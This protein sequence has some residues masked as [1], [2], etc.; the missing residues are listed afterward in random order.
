MH[1]AD[2]AS[3]D[4][5]AEFRHRRHRGPDVQDPDAAEVPLF[6]FGQ[7]SGQSFKE[8]TE[9]EAHYF[10]WAESQ[11]RPSALLKQYLNWVT[12][13]YD[14]NFDKRK[15]SR[16]T[17]G[18]AF[19]ADWEKVY[20]SHRFKAKEPSK[21]EKIFRAKQAQ[22][23]KCN[24]C[25]PFSKAG[26][27][28]HQTVTTCTVCGF[29]EKEKKDATIRTRCPEDCPHLNTNHSSSSKTTHR[30]FCLDCGSVTYE[31]PQSVY[32]ARGCDAPGVGSASNRARP[33]PPQPEKVDKDLN[34]IQALAVVNLLPALAKTYL[35]KSPD[36]RP[37]KSSELHG[38]LDDAIDM[39]LDNDLTAQHSAFMAVCS[40]RKKTRKK[41]LSPEPRR[42]RSRKH[43]KDEREPRRKSSRS[44]PAREQVRESSRTHVR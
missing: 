43:D 14:I 28:A 44:S 23:A 3:S 11:T 6:S 35:K 1:D 2:L 33:P 7:Y 5:E 39:A 32:K 37:V 17:D 10:F 34:K 21:T 8:I 4:S 12:D 40:S 25:G 38:L 18:K 19:D 16:N 26:T 30:V 42:E 20:L 29:R 13:N 22:V 9:E 41:S 24:T 36:G 15:L 31:E 27:N